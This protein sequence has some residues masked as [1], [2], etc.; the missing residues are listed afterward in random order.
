MNPTTD[1]LEA[2]YATGHWLIA[3]DRHRDALSLFRT[4]LLVDARDERGWLA[5]ATCH[6]ALDEPEKAIAL[7][8]LAAS[9]C[10]DGALRCTIARARLHRALGSTAEAVDAYREAARLAEANEHDELAAVVAAEG[11]VS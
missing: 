9:A 11:G 4:M 1:T 6:E 3:L 7:Y 2:L 8:L 5:L 10:E